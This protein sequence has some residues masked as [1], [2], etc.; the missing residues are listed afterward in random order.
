MEEE[1]FLKTQHLDA[2]IFGV[3]SKSLEIM[4]S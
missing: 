1:I 4:L 3:K 2:F